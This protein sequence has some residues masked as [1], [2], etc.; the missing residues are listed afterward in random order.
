MTIGW[1][2]EAADYPVVRMTQID[3]GSGPETAVWCGGT[4]AAPELPDGKLWCLSSQAAVPA[5]AGLIQVT[6][7]F[8]GVND[9]RVI[10]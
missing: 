9:P 2:P 6:E 7:S 4:P 5:G 8:Y 3:T 10:R 1:L